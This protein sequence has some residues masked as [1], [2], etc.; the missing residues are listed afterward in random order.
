MKE[1][2]KD[3]R[4]IT[5][6]FE[7]GEEVMGE[8]KKYCKGEGIEAGQFWVIGAV[9][10]IELAWYD[11][12]QKEYVTKTVTDS[13]EIAGVTGNVATMDGEVIIHAHGTFSD[14]DMQVVAGHVNSMTVSAACEVFMIKLDGQ[15][16]REYSEDLGLNLMKSG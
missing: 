4:R 7:P 14:K 11:L 16:E 15:I 10:E 8:L 12:E 2:L 3:G 5:L 13:L 9:G 1:V 6:S